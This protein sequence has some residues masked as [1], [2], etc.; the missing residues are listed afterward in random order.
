MTQNSSIFRSA[1][2]IGVEGFAPLHESSAREIFAQFTAFL[3]GKHFD[4]VHTR[5]VRH[6]I[7]YKN[8]CGVFC[9]RR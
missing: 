1:A 5:E 7:R 4:P 8:P 2:A 3:F 6:L 9:K